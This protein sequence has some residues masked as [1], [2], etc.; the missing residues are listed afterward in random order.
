MIL[1]W[2]YLYVTCVCARLN[3]FKMLYCICF[4]EFSW[5][6]RG[7][8]HS[9]REMRPRWLPDSAG[10]S[11]GLHAHLL[12]YDTGKWNTIK[13]NNIMQFALSWSQRIFLLF[14]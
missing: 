1:P 7:E 5:G 11:S 10:R 12:S 6:F 13:P 8:G 3:R 2:L 9:E 14:D 4:E